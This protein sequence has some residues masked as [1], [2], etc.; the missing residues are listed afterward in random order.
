VHRVRTDTP[1]QALTTLNDPVFVEA[2]RALAR[3]MEREG[4]ASSSERI[5]YGF[6]LCTSRQ[7][8]AADLGALVAFFEREKDRFERDP[9]AA[10]S[11]LGLPDPEPAGGEPDSPAGA[12]GL[13]MVANVLLNLDTTLTRE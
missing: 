6:R 1:L 4:G 7:P 2:A 10:R 11:F 5:G 12:A 8:A 13:A 3:R 9:K